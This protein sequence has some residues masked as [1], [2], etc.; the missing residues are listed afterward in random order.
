MLDAFII[1]FWQVVAWPAFGYM[2]IGIAIGFFVGLLPG[3]GGLA[4]LALMLPFFLLYWVSQGDLAASVSIFGDK[5]VLDSVVLGW[6]LITAVVALPLWTWLSHRF[7]KRSAYIIA[8]SFWAVVQMLILAV[9]PGQVGFILVLAVLAGMSVS[10]A[11]VLPDAIF[12]DVLEW[13]ELRTR[14]RREGIY[15]GMKNFVRK[16][17]GALAIFSALQALGWFG[18]L[19]A[20][21]SRAQQS[22]RR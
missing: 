20:Q 9:R 3:I 19:A 6:L 10:S 18:Y 15:Y 21:G 16:M 7:S 13:D 2:L 12:H 17:A 22:A 11:H 5:I 1:G 4:T 8:M 14:R